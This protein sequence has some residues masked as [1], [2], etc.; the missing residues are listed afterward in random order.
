MYPNLKMEIWL[1]GLRQNRLARELDV[2]ETLL[3]KVIN[4]FREPSAE[5]RARLAEYF[6]KNENWLFHVET[7]QPLRGPLTNGLTQQSNQDGK[8]TGDKQ[9]R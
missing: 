2:D 8:A 3:S 6:H 5:L 9:Q 1:S 7:V 4:G